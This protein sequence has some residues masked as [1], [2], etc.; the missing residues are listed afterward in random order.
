MDKIYNVG[1]IGAG[2]SG[3]VTALQLAKHGIDSVLFEQEKSV[4]SGPPF[5]HLH[6]GGNLYPDISES[7]CKLLMKQSIEMARL[8]PESIDERPTFISVP[9]T[10]KYEFNKL[11]E[12][13]DMLVQY[14][15]DLIAEDPA[16]K[17]LGA[18]E[19]YYKIYTEAELNVLAK[20]PTIKH[21][22]SPD[23]WMTNTIKLIDYKK[24]KMPVI[25]VQEY[26]WNLFR[27]GAQAQLALDK[28]PFCDLK[29]NTSVTSIKDV[30]KQNLNYNWEITTKDEVYKVNYLVNSC[31]FKAGEF[32]ESLHLNTER[33]IEFKAAYVSKWDPIP[34]LIPEL[35]FHGERGTPRGMVQLTP[36]CDD[37]YQIH[38]MTNEITLFENGLVKS[39]NNVPQPEFEDGIK[40]KLTR[41]WDYKEVKSRTEKA[42]ASVT[43]FVPS[44]KSASVGGP[45]LFGAQQ[46]P[47]DDP[48][49]RIG[50]VRF[51]CKTYARSE[52]VKASSALTVANQILNKIQEIG[53][54]PSIN[55]E[56]SQN[57]IL[58][59]ISKDD[60]DALAE[61]LAEQ[62]GYPKSL[63]RLVIEKK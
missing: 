14:Y 56:G 18:P 7:Q 59:S 49:L 19:H 48:S 32:D 29:T 5:C 54:M 22:K 60:I 46:I 12:R 50:E 55:D 20:Q 51:P 4:V 23:Q 53:I 2:V 42:I 1:I 47:G 11:E 31:G 33:L 52:I 24:L 57:S 61:A 26:G 27:L 17:I 28:T 40:Q 63:S 62:R 44:F 10:E 38:G 21:P 34:G 36:Y 25:L 37:Y 6:A 9:K 3:V 15:E 45:P 43:K 58:E 13:L 39:K 8:F 16:N 35:I 30:R 41:G